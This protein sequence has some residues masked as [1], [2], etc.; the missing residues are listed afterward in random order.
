MPVREVSAEVVTS[1][2]H[3][4]FVTALRRTTQVETVLVRVVDSDGAA[5]RGEGPQTWRITGESLASV[6]ACVN[7]PLREAVVGSDPDDLNAILDRVDEAVFGNY[8]AKAAVDEALHDL[9][10]QRLGVPLTR[11]LG[12]GGH[13]VPT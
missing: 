5:G 10:A 6:A 1:A 4:P 3:T 12:G 11:L 2:L 8:T 9:A 13:A 7:G